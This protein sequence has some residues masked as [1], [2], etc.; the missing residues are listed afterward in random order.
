MSIF[1]QF[2][3]TVNVEELAKKV[4]ETN[5]EFKELP[6]GEYVCMVTG[7]EPTVS[8]SNKPMVKIVFKV[9]E[10]DFSNRL[11]FINQVIEQPF[12]IN[13]ANQLLRGLATDHDVK[14]KDYVSYATLVEDVANDCIDRKECLVEVVV[15]EGKGN[16]AGKFYTNYKVTKAYN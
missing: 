13:I 8:K 10:G 12:Q 4:E 16:N 15:N 14:F 11:I 3:Q 7:M 1:E 2:N 9:I 5:N 6:E